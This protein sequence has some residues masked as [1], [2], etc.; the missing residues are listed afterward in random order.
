M[1]CSTILASLFI[2]L[3]AL[4]ANSDSES[5]QCFTDDFGIISHK[6]VCKKS[7]CG[8]VHPYS[9]RDD[10]DGVLCDSN[11]DCGDGCCKD[12]ICK[13]CPL[14]T[15]MIIIIGVSGVVGLIVLIGL[16]VCCC[17]SCQ[18]QPQVVVGRWNHLHNPNQLNTMPNP[19]ITVVN[20]SSMN[21]NVYIPR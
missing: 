21:A 8:I 6:Y 20:S 11:E 17:R 5:R 7:C 12:N 15:K 2:I 18:R 13:D 19:G 1:A 16:I 3:A 4:V 10:C 14:G 9:C